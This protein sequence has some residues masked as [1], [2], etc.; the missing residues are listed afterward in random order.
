ME[1]KKKCLT[2]G[3]DKKI[4]HFSIISISPKDGSVDHSDICEECSNEE[5]AAVEEATNS[6]RSHCKRDSHSGGVRKSKGRMRRSAI[7]TE[8]LDAVG[9]SLAACVGN[10]LARLESYGAESF[11]NDTGIVSPLDYADIEERAKEYI[12]KVKGLEFPKNVELGCGGTYIVFG[13]TVGAHGHSGILKC[14]SNLSGHIGARPVHVGYAL[15][16]YD[17][18]NPTLLGMDD[19]LL[20]ARRDEVWKLGDVAFERDNITLVRDRVTA[21]N[22]LIRCQYY[23][24]DY[25]S[26]SSK[27]AIPD[28]E[29]YQ[30]VVFDRFLHELHTKTKNDRDCFMVSTGCCCGDFEKRKRKKNKFPKDESELLAHSAESSAAGLRKSESVSYWERGFVVLHV[31]EKG[32]ACPILCRAKIVNDKWTVGYMGDIINEDGVVPADKVDLAI[33]DI[34]VPLHDSRAISVVEKVASILR[35][36]RLINVGDHCNS[37]SLNHH[38]MDRNEPIVDANIRDECGMA[39]YILREMSTWADE[40]VIIMGNH[41]RFMKDFN[42]KVPSLRTLVNERT[43]MGAVEAGYEVIDLKGVYKIG[44]NA[45]YIH[46]EMK[47]FGISGDINAQISDSMDVDTIFGHCHRPSVRCGSYGLGLLA[48]HDQGY[49]ETESSNWVHGYGVVSHYEGQAFM[50]SVP[51]IDY[52]TPIGGE[53]ITYSSDFDKWLPKK[54]DIEIKYTLVEEC[55]Y[56]SMIYAIAPSIF[57]KA[58]MDYEMAKWSGIPNSMLGGRTPASMMSSG[59]YESVYRVLRFML[60]DGRS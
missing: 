14:I 29:G 40:L 38:A 22:A 30:T 13:N 24:S 28:D 44:N 57:G 39:N 8:D 7:D 56:E 51:I 18:V 23:R 45:K 34:H 54:F 49:N 19:L 11:F 27:N 10:D 31:N 53:W 50:N 37:S 4:Y 48:L 9:R 41:E 5:A 33:G 21:G 1:E 3:K 2:C 55:D 16:G 59:E 47:H 12:I 58:N 26:G 35:P 17:C 6:V 36:D 46:G 43:M 60:G 20:V 52:S 25:T 32:M 42:A 15:D